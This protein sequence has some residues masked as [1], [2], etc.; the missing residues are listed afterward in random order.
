MAE[1]NKHGQELPRYLFENVLGTKTSLFPK[2][3]ENG[4][5]HNIDAV[6]GM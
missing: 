3:I 6:L 2:S 4:R 1:L 5:I